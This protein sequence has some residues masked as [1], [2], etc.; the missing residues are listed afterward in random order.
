MQALAVYERPVTSAAIDYLLQPYLP[1]INSALVLNRLVNIQFARKEATRYYLHPVDRAYALSRIPK[2]DKSDRR[3]AAPPLLNF[4]RRGGRGGEVYTQYA[5]LH[6][7]A[8]YF[9][10][11]RQPRETWKKLDDLTPQE[12][13]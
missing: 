8:E 7:G 9:K 10:Q 4:F 11:A 3:A 1:G 12:R 2:G 6:R 5:L 13:I